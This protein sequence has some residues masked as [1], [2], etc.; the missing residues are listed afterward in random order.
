M[1]VRLIVGHSEDCVQL[2]PPVELLDVEPSAPEDVLPVLL[3]VEPPAPDDVLPVLLDVEL[4]ELDDVLPVL[5]DV[6]PLGPDGAPPVPDME[7][8]PGIW[9]SS[10]KQ[11]AADTVTETARVPRSMAA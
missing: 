3:D 5:L 8:A 1:S 7:H 10:G 4:P 6:E 11:D 9:H 2:M